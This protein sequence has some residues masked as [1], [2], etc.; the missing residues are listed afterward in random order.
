MKHVTSLNQNNVEFGEYSLLGGA[1]QLFELHIGM[2]VCSQI[3]KM[4]PGY[5]WTGRRQ[6]GGGEQVSLTSHSG[7]SS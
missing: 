6:E 2:S 7:I 1:M 5:I 3:G 4:K